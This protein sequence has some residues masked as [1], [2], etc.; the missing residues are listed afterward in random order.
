MSVGAAHAPSVEQTDDRVRKAR[1]LA[2][3]ARAVFAAR[4]TSFVERY[5]EIDGYVAIR[6]RSGRGKDSGF[7]VGADPLINRV[8]LAGRALKKHTSWPQEQ[9]KETA[10]F[11]GQIQ[12]VEGAKRIVPSRIWRQ[13]FDNCLV[14]RAKP[15]Y[16]FEWSAFRV[17]E[18]GFA[19][20]DREVG[21]SGFG[22]AVAC[23]E[24]A[25]QD[26]EAAAD[27]VDDDTRFGADDGIDRLDIDKAVQFLSGLRIYIDR[28]G[29]AL[30]LPPPDDSLL[31][32][33]QLGFG[34]TDSSFSV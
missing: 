1:K 5:L 10:V 22:L 34:P 19:P 26:V 18:L 33:W 27:A 28:Y 12:L 7:L 29:I 9:P 8:G 3:R 17:V 14:G 4:N 23:G 16:V 15:L 11:P 21:A 32:G 30:A 25:G 2:E 31:Q 13:T 24:S 20:P 6:R